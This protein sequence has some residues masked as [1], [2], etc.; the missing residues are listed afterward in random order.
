MKGG[1]TDTQQD[2]LAFFNKKN[3]A[4]KPRI[5]DVSAKIRT[6]KFL[7]KLKLDYSNGNGVSVWSVPRELSVDSSAR[8]AVKRGL[9]R[10]KMKNLC[11]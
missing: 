10:V 5:A 9:E 2:H 8:E 7:I 4:E 11:C 6:S 1:G 3:Y